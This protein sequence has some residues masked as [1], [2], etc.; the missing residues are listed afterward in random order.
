MGRLRRSRTHHARRDV[1]RGSRTRVRT[2]DLDQ[3][4]LID[5]DPKNR[6]ALEAQPLDFEAPGLAQHYCVECAKHYETDVALRSHWRSKVHRRRMKDL[7]V[8][9]YTIEESE[10]AAG[11]GRDT[12]RAVAPIA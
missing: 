3:I 7:K 10:R 1:H 2:R 12:R 5:L 4:Q 6:A 9:A 8:P 11:L